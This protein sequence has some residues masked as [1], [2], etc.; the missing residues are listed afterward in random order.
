VKAAVEERSAWAHLGH[1][2]RGGRGKGGVVRRGCA[3]VPFYRVGG[4]SRVA[5]RG[6]ESSA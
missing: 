5:G 6:G 1:G 2:E 3:G 4:G